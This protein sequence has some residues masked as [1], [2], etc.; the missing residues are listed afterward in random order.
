M[1]ILTLYSAPNVHGKA[2]L[3]THTRQSVGLTEISQ[4]IQARRGDG[5]KGWRRIRRAAPRPLRG[6]FLT[7]GSCLAPPLVKVQYGMVEDQ[8]TRL[9]YNGV[10]TETWI[11]SSP[12]TS[13]I[14]LAVGLSPGARQLRPLRL[15]N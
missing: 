3:V 7:H 1:M 9:T 14:E 11:M 5:R 12:A 10:F 4:G 8:L 2:M 6:F 13:L 15:A